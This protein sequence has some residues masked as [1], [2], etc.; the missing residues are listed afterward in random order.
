MATLVE[1]KT[2]VTVR[3]RPGGSRDHA[4]WESETF[5]TKREAMHFKID[6]E[7]AGHQWP[8]NA[9]GLPWVKGIG[10][11]SAEELAV[12]RAEQAIGDST[13]FVK[14]AQRHIESKLGAKDIG[15]DMFRRY[16][17]YAR[18][19]EGAVPVALR[20]TEILEE[21]DDLRL[22][23]LV[24]PKSVGNL[25]DTIEVSDTA[26]PLCIEDVDKDTVAAWV[27]WMRIRGVM[28]KTIR[29]HHGFLHGVFKEA[30][31]DE[32]IVRDPCGNTKLGKR[33]VGRP[34]VILEREEFWAIYDAI[35]PDSRDFIETAVGTGMR[36]GEITA[37]TCH[38][39]K[40]G[41]GIIDVNKAWKRG[42]SG[43]IIGKPKTDAGLRK[44]WVSDPIAEIMDRLTDG[45]D[46]SD[47][48]FTAP[49]GGRLRQSEFGNR[50]LVAVA[51]ARQD[52]GLAKQPRFH[53]LR[54]TCISW[55]R[56]AGLPDV[57]IK[58]LVGHSD[59]SM[60]EKYGNVTSLTIATAR[61]AMG[62]SLLRAA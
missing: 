2:N 42:I 45:R 9:E 61:T 4:G 38:D 57:A 12:I 5:A 46:P 15:E 28:P 44:V 60:T 20:L 10:Y 43:D 14:Y 59:E 37:L 1:N 21:D 56:D 58:D 52:A 11:V 16:G 13:P 62:Q 33:E 31:E 23:A 6:V 36:F 32:L 19:F 8:V 30:L 40:K 51:R 47:L 35:K 17:Q 24:D 48:I 18:A 39:W 29:N 22:R 41:D 55:L 49:R 50:W 25:L 3:W 26:G 27:T 54:H 7:E 34:K 53:D